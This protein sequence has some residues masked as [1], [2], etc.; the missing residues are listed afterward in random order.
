VLARVMHDDKVASD[1]LLSI[2]LLERK[3]EKKEKN[4][5]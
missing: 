5:V 4:R 1:E 2:L 3:K